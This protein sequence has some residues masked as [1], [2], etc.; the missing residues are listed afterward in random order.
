[1]YIFRRFSYFFRRVKTIV[2][3]SFLEIKYRAMTSTISEIIS[4]HWLL[5]D[6]SVSL[7]YLILMYFD[8]KSI[9][10]IAHNSIFHKR[11]KYIEID[12][13]SH[14]TCHHLQHNTLSF[15]S[16]SLHIVNL[17]IKPHSN[18]YF[19]YYFLLVKSQCFLQSHY[20]FT[21]MLEIF[22]C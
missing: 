20:K 9:V 10:Q 22:I 15:V 18:L 2:S 4:L 3:W 5:T 1:M 21:G 7:S 13:H 17:F 6:I 14:L 11:I 8:N 12:C 16:S 19:F